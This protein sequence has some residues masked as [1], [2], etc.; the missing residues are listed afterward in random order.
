MA[1]LKG[2]VP[3]S[4]TEKVKILA[5]QA[6]CPPQNLGLTCVGQAWQFEAPGPYWPELM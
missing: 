4:A 6:P 1:A 3:F 2:E 5:Q